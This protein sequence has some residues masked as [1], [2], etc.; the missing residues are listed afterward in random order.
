MQIE[1]EMIT[2]FPTGAGNMGEGSWKIDGGGGGSL[3]QYMGR[4]WGTKNAVEKYLWRSS[5]NSKVADY[6]PA[7]LQIY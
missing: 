3:S 7:S 1:K 2:G 5:F 6:K 4:A